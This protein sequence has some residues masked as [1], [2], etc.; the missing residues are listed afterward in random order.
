MLANGP[1]PVH[2]KARIKGGNGHLSNLECAEAIANYA[3]QKLKHVWLCH[4]SEENNHPILA[5]K[6]VEQT[7]R[8]YGLIP[9]KDFMVEDLKRKTPSKLYE[10]T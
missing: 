4:L 2:L 7:L 10:L 8:S 6:T 3:T 9:G 5:L 1:Y